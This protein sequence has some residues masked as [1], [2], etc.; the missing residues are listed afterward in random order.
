MTAAVALL[1]LAAAAY[2]VHIAAKAARRLE[3]AAQVIRDARTDIDQRDD[4][5]AELRALLE[6]SP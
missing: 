3:A 1:A 4:Q 2:L 6:A 5:I